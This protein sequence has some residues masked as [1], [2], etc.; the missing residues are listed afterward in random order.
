LGTDAQVWTFVQRRGN[1]QL[2]LDEIRR[3]FCDL[4]RDL[5]VA[6]QEAPDDVAIVDE[7]L[8][9]QPARS[10]KRDLRESLTK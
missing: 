6:Q 3:H 8:E 5:D 9:R 4:V 7:F 10:A 2:S 1:R